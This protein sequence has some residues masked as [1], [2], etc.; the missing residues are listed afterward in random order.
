MMPTPLATGTEASA[1]HRAL[2]PRGIAVVGASRDPTKRGHQVVRA[3]LDRGFGG[4]VVPVNPAGGEVLGLPASPSLESA[5]GPL[6]LAVICTPAASVPEVIRSCGR[7]GIAGAVVLAA[8]FGEL[9]EGGEALEAELVRA[10]REA[11]VRVVGPNTSGILNLPL[12]LDLIGV[13]GIRPGSLA[14]LTQSGNMSLTLL[15]EAA[16][17]PGEGFSMVIGVGNEADAAFHEYLELLGADPGIRAILVHAESF[18]Q[19]GRFLEAAREVGRNTPVVVLKGGRTRAGDQAARSHTGAVATDHA[20]IRSGLRGAGIIEVTRSDDLLAVGRTLATQP[21]AA[22]PAGRTGTEQTGAGLLI[23]ADGGGQGTLAADMLEE[24][25]V[26]LAVPDEATRTALRTLLGPNAALANPVDLAGA[27]DRDPGV[28]ARALELVLRDPAVAGVLMV[29]LF[30]G[31]ALRFAAELE[32]AEGEAALALASRARGA[33]KPLVIHSI[34]G[35][36]DTPAIRILHR[37][38]VPLF[39]SLETACRAA[40]ATWERARLLQRL[41]RVPFPSG[42]PR[43]SGASHPEPPGFRSDP[44]AGIAVDPVPVA[45]AEG[46]TT[47]LETETRALLAGF[48][49]PLVPAHFCTSVEDAVAALE[50][51]GAP[52]VLRAVSDTILHKSEAGGVALGLTTPDEVSAAHARVLEDVTRFAMSR[53]LEHG[54]RGVLVSPML[55]PPRVELLVGMRRSPSFGPVISLGAGGVAVEVHRDVAVRILPL[56]E[57]E[58]TEMVEELRIAPLLRGYR[59]Q[60]GVDLSALAALVEGLARCAEAL[61][62]IAEIEMNPVFATSAGVVAVDAR[63]YLAAAAPSGV[64]TGVPAPAAGL[65]RGP[66]PAPTA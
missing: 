64:A 60:P 22:P 38:G 2:H 65:E 16:D 40:A 28:F 54:L 1:L 35:E 8:G 41:H 58:V 33:G 18:R 42:A 49:V 13:A 4:A 3:L 23:L 15:R 21:P 62:E 66:T 32:G 34:Y 30:G 36:A 27:A 11:G 53:G 31:Y 56:A 26:P 57:G 59:G 46:R 9:G 20:V 29:S 52:V 61:P 24:L 14:L 19:G 48:G 47:L 51:F 37:E 55:P 63:A 44:G 10:A 5:P 6:D 25:G 7:R 50:R 45:R 12:G 43:P 39:R 17:R